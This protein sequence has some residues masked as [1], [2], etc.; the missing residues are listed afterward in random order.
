M[1]RINYEQDIRPLSEF[2]AEVSTCIQQVTETKRPMI[3]TQRGRGVAVLVDVGEF[4]AMQSKLELLGD[5]YKA[6]SQLARGEG[7]PHESAKSMV[8]KRIKR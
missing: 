5:I 6:E 8:L 7:I 4:E 2:R 3:I 1:K